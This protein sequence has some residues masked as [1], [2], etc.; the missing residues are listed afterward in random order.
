MKT[1]WSFD[2]GKASIGEAVRDVATDDFPHKASL[3]IPQDFADTRPAAGRRR[4][5]R[6]RQAHKA[7]EAWLDEVWRAAGLQPLTGRRV[8]REN[9]KW[10]AVEETA[11]QRERRG[12]LEREF[13]AKGDPT[14]YNSSLLRIKLLDPRT[15]APGEVL[16]D[17]Q[18]YKA[19]HSAIQKRGY[20]RVPW[21]TRAAKRGE[22]N[23]EELVSALLKKDPA[24]LTDEEK[25]YRAAVEAWPKFKQEVPDSAFHFP[26][27]YDAR[28]MDLWS[29]DKPATLRDRID[30]TAEST[31]KIR[32]DRS[33]VENEIAILARRAAELLPAIA[34][35]FSRFREEGCTVKWTENPLRLT[36]HYGKVD[37][38]DGA[39]AFDVTASDFGAFLV[40]GPAGEP[41]ESAREDF[42]GYLA[43][44]TKHGL[45]PGSTDDWLG[46]I[47]QKTPRFDNRIINDCALIS[48]LQ[49][50]NVAVRFD[51][52][53]GQPYP[54]S[55]LASE[56]TFLMKLK[57]TL[58]NDE[59][60]PRKLRP[61]EVREIFAIVTADARAVRPDEKNA[62]HKVVSHYSLGKSDWGSAKSL[63]KLGLRTMANHEE[64]KAPKVEG[65]SRFSRPALRLIRA[66]ILSGQK[67]S[68]FYGRLLAREPA[69]LDEMGMD[70]L[71]AEPARFVGKN[72]TE[73]KFMK[74]DRPWVLK[75]D[76]TFFA[77]LARKNA[78]GEGD[79]WEDLYFPEQRLY[80]LE[81]RHKDEAGKVDVPNA[82]REII[83]SINDP[84]VRHRLGVFADRIGEHHARFGVPEELVLEFIRE[85]FMG[86][87]AKFELRRF[88]NE[89]EKARKEAKERAA[90]LGAGERSGQLKYELFKMQG[91]ACPYCQQP[92][93]QTE[94]TNYRIE[95]IV[96]RQQGGPDAMVNYVL[97]HEACN[98]AKG[99]MTPFQWK[100]G[101][102]GWD[103]YETWVKRH[104]TALRNKK[105]QLLLQ[106]DAPELVQRYTALA[107]TA[108]IAKLAQK[109][110]SL[111]FGWRNGN[112]LSGS[113]PVKRVTVI[114]GG[115]TA[116]IRRAYRLNS[117][118]APM[119]AK[120][121][122]EALQRAAE[123]KQSPLTAEE[124]A[125]VTKEAAYE[126][127][128]VAEKNR[129][130][131][132]HHALDAMVINFLPQWTR[133]ARKEHFFR[134]PERIQRNAQA[135]F[136]EE[137][138][139][140]RPV[141]LARVKPAL[142]ETF[143]GMRSLNGANYIV[144]R[145]PLFDLA[146]KE[147]KGKLELR[148]R[149]DIEPHKIVDG[150]IRELVAEFL[151]AHPD[152]TLEQWRDWCA[153]LRLSPNGPRIVKVLMTETKRDAVEEYGRFGKA[154]NA[155]REQYR[156]G[157]SHAG[158]FVFTL[159]ATAKKE[160]GKRPVR[161]QPVYAFQQRAAVEKELRSTPGVEIGGYFWAG[162]QVILAKEWEFKGERFP[163]DEY[164]LRT[165]WT[166]GNAIL[167]H[168]AHGFIGAKPKHNAPIPLWILVDAGM[169]PK[170]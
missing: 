121:L 142:E 4:M 135:Y 89:R 86:E 52:K 158:Y 38:S 128:S 1:V 119:P 62:E 118:L 98:D 66:L 23:E 91:D 78:K 83:G 157:A 8:E 105:V 39:K 107:E 67:P 17:W 145:R 35:S 56:V 112:D 156:R 26:A 59:P 97:A 64:V 6:T 19:L 130:D 28:K 104:A 85:D 101:R 51:K 131:D 37:S 55:L 109:I 73:K 16:A 71:D 152:L 148:A 57:N 2:L 41:S 160:S 31:R 9:G 81:A 153:T 58:V 61:E 53:T 69:L 42:A 138:A 5:W 122:T 45:H 3:L 54:D 94:L 32:F 70:V 50:C 24:K 100:H 161:V 76:L 110:V 126:W 166:Q 46:A 63:K 95:H 132:R 87:Q 151:G 167:K 93:F 47:G 155:G 120:F 144:K 21:A 113:K 92:F 102:E 116:R 65:R 140:V 106:E 11:E 44:R 139:A 150:A 137:I 34:A 7:R 77:D 146:V 74:R 108:W 40:H 49:V 48:R 125:L 75:G 99:E 82:V 159:P 20:G 88:Q 25:V 143:Y 164:T 103:A 127:E 43:F 149:K 29:P 163:A 136:R 30:C 72:G 80:A 147:V 60:K 133:D 117:L 33:D 10:K 124:S 115:L 165:L 123:R 13:P 154:G 36:L 134:F 18:I 14:C 90:D 84:V 96:P 129:Q 22:Q 170:P 27:Y 12:W 15:P 114:S 79:T 111:H 68:E 162:C 169:K 168:G 141:S